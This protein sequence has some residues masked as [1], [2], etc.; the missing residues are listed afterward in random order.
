MSAIS[1]NPP[2]SEPAHR[3]RRLGKADGAIVPAW[4]SIS[5]RAAGY[6]S[7]PSNYILALSKQLAAD[8][9]SQPEGLARMHFMR[10]D[11]DGRIHL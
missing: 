10:G 2:G 8:I 4:F 11:S 9:A 5:S 3:E 1:A 7:A 6:L